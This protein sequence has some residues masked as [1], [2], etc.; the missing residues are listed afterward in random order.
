MI[1]SNEE[2]EE[3]KLSNNINLIDKLALENSYVK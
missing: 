1:F 3:L 2:Y